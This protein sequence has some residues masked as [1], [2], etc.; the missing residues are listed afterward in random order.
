M[1]HI[2]EWRIPYKRLQSEIKNGL[3]TGV[4][5]KIKIENNR[6]ETGCE[7][8]GWMDIQWVWKEYGVGMWTGLTS[9][10]YGSV[11][12]R[13]DVIMNFRSFTKTENLSAELLLI[14]VTGV[15]LSGDVP[16]LICPVYR[17]SSITSRSPFVSQGEAKLLEFLTYVQRIYVILDMSYDSSTWVACVTKIEGYAIPLW[18]NT[19]FE[20]RLKDSISESHFYNHDV[21]QRLLWK[22]PHCPLDKNNSK[23]IFDASTRNI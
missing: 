8:V 15:S 19:G 9:L 14:E 13:V 7:N 4:G 6:K 12:D 23:F 18:S 3:N 20:L 21:S 17:G 11:A 1:Q 22:C 10:G 16:V 5:G 2:Q